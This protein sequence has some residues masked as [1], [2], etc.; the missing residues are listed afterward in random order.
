MRV[1]VLHEYGAPGHFRALEALLRMRDLPLPR[2]REFSSRY[3]WKRLLKHGDPK[4]LS[5][6][7]G[8]LLALACLAATAG[9]VVVLGMAPFDPRMVVLRWM[10]R[11]HRVVYFT[12]WHVWDGSR[13]PKGCPGDRQAVQR[14]W[15]RFLE[16]DA[17]GICA[18]TAP[19]LESLR[20]NYA[21]AAPAA[22]VWHGVDPETYHPR[23]RRDDDV[24]PLRILFVGELIHRKGIDR[25]AKLIDHP[26]LTDCRWTVVGEGPERAALEALPRGAGRVDLLGFIADNRAL[27]DIYR[28]HDVLVLPTREE[29]FGMVIIEAMACGVVPL[30]TDVF[31]PRQIL[32]GDTGGIL[33]KEN[34]FVA[35]AANHLA[36]LS[37][38]RPE[39][40]RRRKAVIA[41]AERFHVAALAARWATVLD[42]LLG[43]AEA[44]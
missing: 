37:A 36:V 32:D 17:A 10:L 16:D 30:S 23:G 39:L 24:A 42:P 2:Y 9:E 14:A 21:I 34:N 12:S 29:P 3:G 35:Q 22:V 43:N 40:R 25:L 6:W 11:R 7:P 41:E 13:H 15:R 4:P 38:D 44:S 20:A 5:R 27:A 18:V 1:T 28:G 26:L 19:V 33:L 31:G 8:N